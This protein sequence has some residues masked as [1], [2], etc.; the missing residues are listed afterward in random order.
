MEIRD[1]Y[2]KRKTEVA[3]TDDFND[4][5]SALELPNGDLTVNAASM[6]SPN[7][8]ERESEEFPH[9]TGFDDECESTHSPVLSELIQEQCEK[10]APTMEVQAEKIKEIFEAT[11]ELQFDHWKNLDVDERKKIL[12]DFEKDIAKVEKR[13]LMP[14]EYE[15]LCNGVK[16]YNDGQNLVV[17]EKVLRS[18]DYADYKEI[19]NT[20]FHEGRHSYQN[21]NLYVSRTE[22]SDE[23]F[24]AWK[25]NREELGY[26][27][28]DVSFPFNLSKSF[29][30]KGFYRYYTQPV[31]VDARLFAETVERKLGL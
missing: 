1:I 8:S 31:E 20:F 21:Y 23:T 15:K 13:Y 30:R 6:E 17:S 26:S 3:E 7:D 9:I 5:L 11:P 18:N 2:L 19:L 14:V 16:G 22:R 27:S 10:Y 25:A 12:N 24:D 28:G 29:R 4:R